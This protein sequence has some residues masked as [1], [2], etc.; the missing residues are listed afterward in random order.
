MATGM[1]QPLEGILVLDLTQV[2][3][4]PFCTML[5][6]DL[7]ADVIKIEP[8]EGDLSRRMGGARLRLNG[9]DNAPFLALN[10]NKRSVVLDLKSEDDR[11][12]LLEM[13]A[14]ADVMVESFRPGVVT[15]LGVDYDAVSSL[16]PGIVYASISGFGQTGPYA[17]RPGFDLIAQG[18]AGVLSVTGE[19]EGPPV[20]CGIP[21][22]DLAA[23]L[24][25]ANGIMA[26]LLARTR[27][28]EGQYV[29]TSLFEAALAL[30]VWES[31]EYWATGEAP[32]PCGSAHR[33][34]AP[35]QA[36]RTAD[37][38]ITVA[39][40]TSAQWMKL[41]RVIGRADL[42]DDARF[43]SNE[44]RMSNLPELVDALESALAA[45]PTDTWIDRLL[46]EGVPAGPIHDYH[47]VFEDPH[48]AARGMVEEIEHAVEGVIR[49]LGFPLKMSATP[50]RVRR[51]PPLLG[52]HTA[53]VLGEFAT[54]TRN[55]Q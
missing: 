22:A 13:V 47:Q 33:L 6:G 23:G 7:G 18:M 49:T 12:R 38:Y 50:S 15:R 20:K 3:A 26:A 37:G 28:R 36:L 30:S 54:R 14:S 42:A 24:F 29:E 27:T 10:R 52:E 44:A 17:D 8:P 53:E 25:A 34:N 5:L 48:T 51:A 4:G 2:M 45:A 40:L 21:I 16:N 1:T 41:C 9:E 55:A 11:R 32:K 35:Y 39:A 46:A 31:T 19:R 43:A